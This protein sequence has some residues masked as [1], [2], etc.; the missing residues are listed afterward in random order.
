[1][2]QTKKFLFIY[3]LFIITAL[4]CACKKENMFDLVKGTG[5]RIVEIRQLP[6]FTKIYLKDN[7]NVFITPGSQYVKV[8]AGEKLVPLVRT[9][10]EDDILYIED[11]NKFNWARSY[12]KGVIN[13]HISMPTLRYIWHYGS[14]NVY[15]NDTLICDTLDVETRE[16]GNVELTVKAHIIYTHL[17]GTSDVTLKGKS[18]LMGSFHM[19]EGYFYAQDLVTTETWFFTKASGNEYLNVTRGLSGKIAWAGDVY[20]KGNPVYMSVIR[21]GKGKLIRI[22]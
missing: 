1:M 3:V 20:L 18:D 4:L 21:Q 8:E 22:N 2:K 5:K 19:G 9:R 7:V 13:V 17:H 16:T 10:V 15:G 14:G 12:K 11:D 6:P